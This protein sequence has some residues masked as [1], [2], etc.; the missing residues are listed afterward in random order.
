MDKQDL[1]EIFLAPIIGSI[2][3]TIIILTILKIMGLI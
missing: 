2:S 3:S 1:K